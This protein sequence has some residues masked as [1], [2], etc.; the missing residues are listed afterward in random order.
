MRELVIGDSLKQKA[1]IS[2]IISVVGVVLLS[3]H[4]DQR[5]SAA[6]MTIHVARCGR[7]THR[8]ARFWHSVSQYTA[9]L[10]GQCRAPGNVGNPQ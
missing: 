1:N 8:Q 10:H 6:Q 2:D 7:I 9:W 5:M 3:F 4:T